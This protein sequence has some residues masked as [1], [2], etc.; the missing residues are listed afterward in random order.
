MR[1]WD[2]PAYEDISLTQKFLEWFMTPDPENREE[3]ILDLDGTCIGK[4]G[5]WAKPE[6]G[7]IVHPN[8]WRLGF[9]FEAM[10]ALIPRILD[11]FPDLENLTAECDPRNT[12]SIALLHKLGFRLTRT[13][14][15]N[16]D[17]GGIETCDTAYFELK[18]ET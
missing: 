2:R 13:E 1:Y 14:K 5:M 10:Q 11:R 9:A 16:F 15:Q 4:A 17:Y 7:F 8:Y 18:R 12:S 6:V 3:Y